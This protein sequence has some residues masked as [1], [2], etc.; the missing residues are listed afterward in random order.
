[1]KKLLAALAIALFC[2]SFAW[3]EEGGRLVALVGVGTEPYT[4]AQFYNPEGNTAP[5]KVTV[6]ITDQGADFV[7]E[8]LPQPAAEPTSTIEPTITGE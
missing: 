8:I 4:K 7:W 3:A 6:T 5:I 2:A 1:V